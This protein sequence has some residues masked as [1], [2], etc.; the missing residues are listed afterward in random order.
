MNAHALP[1]LPVSTL[2][3]E[4]P[5]PE[6]SRWKVV[7]E[8]WLRFCRNRA[9]VAGLAILL[10]FFTIALVAPFATTYRPEENHLEDKLL[11]P[12][13]AH[14]LGTDHLGRDILARLAYGARFS[15]LIGFAAIGLGLAI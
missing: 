14:V 6:R 3:R 5:R 10:V 4:T 12:S 7:R 9:A 15:L 1:R 2:P 11:E 8:M 13:P